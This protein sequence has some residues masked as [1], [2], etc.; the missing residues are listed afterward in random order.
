LFADPSIAPGTTFDGRVQLF[1]APDGTIPLFEE[2]QPGLTVADDN[3]FSF[4]FGSQTPSGLNPDN[5][6]SGTSRY[7][8]VLDNLT[9]A[10]V[11]P[12]GARIPLNAT[13]FAL[14]PGPQGATGPMGAPGP[15]GAT[16][17][18]GPAGA[19]GPTGATGAM[20]PVGPTGPTGAMGA[21]GPIGPTGATGATGPGLVPGG[22]I[23]PANRSDWIT[24]FRNT[25]VGDGVEA[26]TVGGGGTAALYGLATGV[27]SNGVI[28]IASNGTSAYG[29]WGQSTSGFAGY[30]S[31]RLNATGALSAASG[32]FSGLVTAS[33]AGDAFSGT[34]TAG[35]SNAGVRG[36]STAP[37]GNGV[38][39]TA[40]NGS[41]AYGIWATS[42][43]GL[44]GRFDGAVQVNG[45]LSASVVQ[46]TGSDFSERFEVRGEKTK[47]EPGM[48]V[49]IDPGNPGKLAVS[50]RA[51]DRRVVGILSGAGG[52][53]AGM[54]MGQP[55]TL[56]DGD[57]PVA[58]SGRVYVW[59]DASNGPIVAGDLLTTSKVPGHAMKVTNH[60][61]A[62]GA[63]LGKA[64]TGL[65]SGR[66]LVLVLVTLQ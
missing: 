14:S 8:D 4:L 20:G 2:L 7:L 56:A 38:I 11:L 52:V 29:V 36:V 53:R 59:A 57:Q 23:G 1:D 24:A 63:I 13:A 64:M 15:T 17:A 18:P 49:S 10:S 48:V 44:A 19:T 5:F 60:G 22:F 32:S 65:S 30:F 21:M 55:G 40:N 9:S 54:L 26:E 43:S 51:Y 28:G 33:N 42:A 16:G 50:T 58:I 41:A 45:N 35:A 39:A 46:I 12:G 62:Q 66:G 3:S 37:N 25:G 31:G 34:S 47:V 27:N 61:K 6:Q